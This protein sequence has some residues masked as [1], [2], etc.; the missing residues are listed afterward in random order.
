MNKNIIP[1]STQMPNEFLDRLFPRIPEAEHRCLEYI[2]RRTFGFHKDED[3]ISLTQFIY[4]ILGKDYGTGLSR[5]SVVEA[6]RNLVKAGVILKKDN[7]TGNYF[8]VNLSIDVDKVVQEINRF[9]KQTKSSIANRPK[10]VHLLYPQKKGN[11][12]NKAKRFF[13][14]NAVEVLTDYYYELK[15][16]TNQPKA[17][18]R[19]NKIS[20]SRNCKTA[21]DI[22]YLCSGGIDEAKGKVLRVCEWAKKNNLE[23]SLETIIKRFYAKND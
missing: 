2:C 10:A 17:Y 14:K 6:L 23:W 9:R 16:W 7:T 19:Q 18:L 12:G 11:K 4:G 15:G 20:Y 5:A 21:R 22:L 3:Q 8:K 13:K 1:N